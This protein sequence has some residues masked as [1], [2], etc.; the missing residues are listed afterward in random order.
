[1]LRRL[2]A[3]ALTV[4]SLCAPAQAEPRE[5]L[6]WGRLFTNDRIG[7]RGDRWRTG[8]YHL[9]LVRGPN[10]EGHAPARPGALLEYRLRAEIISPAQ[11]SGPGP[12]DRP[13]VGAISLGVHSHWQ[14]QHWQLEAGGDLVA[15]GPSTGLSGF[16]RWAHD[17]MSSPRLGSVEDRQLDDALHLSFSTE[18]ARPVDLGERVWLRP[19]VAAQAGPETLVRAG[20]DMF[21]GGL[22]RHD[23]LVRDQVTGQLIRAVEGEHAALAIV[24]GADAARV[25]DSAWLPEP[26]EAKDVR[27]R[28]RAGLHWQIS[29]DMS[30][31]YGATWLSEEF[32]AQSE[33][34][35]LGGLKVNLNF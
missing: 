10:W 17:A 16:H 28:A 27:L 18:A 11:L 20:A 13:Y 14:P 25:T 15:V 24:L 2:I 30:F 22:G 23:L 1:M 21:F 26:V 34:Q 8:S 4:S 19:F 3:A 32:E 31:F 33:P 6:G 9:S 35:V 29:D 5:T 12:D 7:D